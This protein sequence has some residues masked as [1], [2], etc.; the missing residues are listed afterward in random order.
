MDFD[1]DDEDN[2]VP[3]F[4]KWLLWFDVFFLSVGFGDVLDDTEFATN[5][6]MG[7]VV[8][9]AVGV[10]LM[11]YL[12]LR[13]FEWF[14]K[15]ENE[16]VKV[17]VCAQGLVVLPVSVGIVDYMFC[18]SAVVHLAEVNK[19]G[20]TKGEAFVK[21][22]NEKFFADFVCLDDYSKHYRVRTKEFDWCEVGDTLSVPISMGLFGWDIVH[23]DEIE[24]I[25]TSTHDVENI[26]GD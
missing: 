3:S 23:Y 4:V 5:A 25:S 21:P 8:F 11:T 10:S 18:G 15:L 22:G 14:D 13:H 9:G 19:V 12:I 26:N 1:E 24:K 7:Y 20:N 16:V 17:L 6:V 2:N